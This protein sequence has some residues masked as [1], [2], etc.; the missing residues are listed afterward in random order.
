MPFHKL[1]SQP[2]LCAVQS[3]VLTNRPANF[4]ICHP[5]N[6]PANLT[7]HPAF[8]SSRP[9]CHPRNPKPTFLC[10]IQGTVLPIFL[11]PIYE[12]APSSVP[13]IIPIVP[14]SMPS[15]K[16][17]LN[18][19]LFHPRHRPANLLLSRL[20]EGCKLH[21][22]L[23]LCHPCNPPAYFPLCHPRNRLANLPLSPL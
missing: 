10:A 5:D 6:R 12:V 21:A 22:N 1:S 8:Q 19:P 14:S 11:C 4:P 3:N 7:L 9:L 15:N 13:S 17:A 20:R 16:P 2:T 23:P 18:L